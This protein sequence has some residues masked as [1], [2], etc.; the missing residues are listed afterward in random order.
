MKKA[1]IH[2]SD[3]HVTAILNEKNENSKKAEEVWL[4]TDKNDP[5]N[6][7]YIN[8]FCDF[9]KENYKNRKFYLLI[10]GDIANQASEIEYD[11]AQEYLSDMLTQLEIPKERLL[12]VPGDHDINRYECQKAFMEGKKNNPSKKPYAYNEEKYSYFSSFYEKIRSKK[13][14]SNKNI[15]DILDFKDEKILLVGI[16]SNY[17]IDY[18]GG[19]GAVNIEYLKEELQNIDEKYK[20]YS[21][22]A[23]FHH[24]PYASYEDSYIGQWDKDNLV[25]FIRVLNSFQFKVLFH[26]NEH[27]RNSRFIDQIYSS[28]CGSFAKKKPAPSFKIY[29]IEY[30]ENK[31]YLSLYLIVLQNAN[32]NIEHEF[33]AWGEQNCR[34][35]GEVEKIVLKESFSSNEITPDSTLDSKNSDENKTKVQSTETLAPKPYS[36]PTTKAELL[37]RVKNEQ[38]YHSGHFHWSETSRAH[39]WIDASTLLNKVDNLEYSQSAILDIIEHE[40]IEY[41]FIIGLGMEGNLLSTGLLFKSNKPY[42]F[43]PYSYRYDEHNLYEKKLNY[44][45]DGRYKTIL[46]ITDVVNEGRTLRKLINKRE[47]DFFAKVEDIIVVSLFYAGNKTSNSI[48]ILNRKDDASFDKENDHIENRI[49][50]YYVLDLQVEKCPHSNN[51]RNE[52]TIYKEKLCTIYRFYDEDKA[53]SKKETVV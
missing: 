40:K 36:N 12:I 11:F 34:H 49:R 7:Y 17:K 15:I 9:I 26:G 50:Y 41:D 45:N 48:S 52:C 39:N 23:V 24:N 46:I 16:N 32:K 47:K 20:E 43:L 21:K 3:L 29:D 13:F 6:S 33:G 25:E 44:S 31:T 22:I 30:T 37:K 4:N 35:M 14:D 8:A 19:D 53:L 5:N 18:E 2:I 51:F 38:V 1:I 27:T 28:D 42:S 10:S